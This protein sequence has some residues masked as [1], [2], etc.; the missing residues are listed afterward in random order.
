VEL[1]ADE[2]QSLAHLNRNNSGGSATAGIRAVSLLLR[3]EKLLKS[4]FWIK[5][6]QQ[7]SLQ[8]TL[9]PLRLMIRT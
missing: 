4:I 7:M 5:V 3:L 2:Q 8:S 6:C 1:I 9:D